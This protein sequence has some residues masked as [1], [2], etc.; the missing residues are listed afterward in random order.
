M[1]VYVFMYACMYVCMYVCMSIYIYLYIYVYVCVHVYT[2]IYIYVYVHIYIYIYTY[3]CTHDRSCRVCFGIV[4]DSSLD[5][6]SQKRLR[7]HH[8]KQNSAI[9]WVAVKELEL[10]YHNGYI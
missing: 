4:A 6:F 9:R 1:C 5:V 8:T 10:S 3:M 7:Q 2:Y